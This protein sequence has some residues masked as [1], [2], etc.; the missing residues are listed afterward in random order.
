MLDFEEDLKTLEHKLVDL[1]YA[2]RVYASLC[3]V[4]WVHNSAPQDWYNYLEQKELDWE[5]KNKVFWRK[6][7]RN[8]FHWLRNFILN[9]KSWSWLNM[10]L[11]DLEYLFWI[12]PNPEPNWI[13]S[14]SWRYASGLVADIRD[15]DEDYLNFY[16]NGK[17]GIIDEEFAKDM[18]KLGWKPVVNKS[19]CTK[20]NYGRNYGNYQK[21]YN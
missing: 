5:R 6:W 20:I 2:N 8:F 17:E 14:C 18:E 3:N 7:S 16:C 21:K 4:Q 11:L 9:K 15:V 12:F 1:F 19:S 10:G 13:Y